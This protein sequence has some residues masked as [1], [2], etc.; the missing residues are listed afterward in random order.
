[1]PSR[2]CSSC[3]VKW[4]REDRFALCPVCGTTTGVLQ[5]AEPSDDWEARYT[6]ARKYASPEAKIAQMRLDRFIAAGLDI[7]RSLSWA[8]EAVDLHLFERLC[9]QGCPM[10]VAAR[11]VAP[12][13]TG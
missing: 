9:K 5:V 13:P 4:P 11:I 8:S 10:E 3:E 1:M 6:A 2:R 12:L 7:G